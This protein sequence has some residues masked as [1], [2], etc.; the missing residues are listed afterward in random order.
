MLPNRT[1]DELEGRDPRPEYPSSYTVGLDLATGIVVSL[2][3]YGGD[4]GYDPGF[5]VEILSSE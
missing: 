1:S 5:E 3:A 2:E 4:L